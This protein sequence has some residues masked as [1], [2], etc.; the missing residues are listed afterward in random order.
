MV[1]QYKQMA[2]YLDNHLKLSFKREFVAKDESD[3]YAR[4]I[5]P[6]R[7]GLDFLGYVIH[8]YHT[9]VRKRVI[10]NY[11]YKKAHYLERYEK[12]RGKMNL[13]EIRAFLSVQASFVGHIK[14]ADSFNLLNKVGRID[15]KNPFDFDRA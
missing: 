11:K 6:N 10:K 2:K 8:P 9:L 13:E 12:S 7:Q 1:Y 5:K 3:I 15:E 4:I 14:H